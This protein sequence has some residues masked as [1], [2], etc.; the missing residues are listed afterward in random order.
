MNNVSVPD[1][2]GKKSTVLRSAV[3]FGANAAGKSNLFRALTAA[4]LMIRNSSIMQPNQPL[5]GIV[6]FEPDPAYHTKPTSFE[7]V[8]ITN[9]RK[10]V[11]GFS[12]TRERVVKE[13][14]YVYY[15]SKASTIFTRDVERDPEI[16]F[17]N[18]AI[19]RELSPMIQMNTP[20]K[21]FLSTATIWNSVTTKVPYLWFATNI[22]V[23]TNKYD[24]LLQFF[25]DM[26]DKDNVAG[27]REFIIKTMR[28][29]D[30]SIDGYSVSRHELSS[31]QMAKLPEINLLGMLSNLSI[32]SGVG[33]QITAKHHA[34]GVDGNQHNYEFTM[35]D[36][37]EGTRNIFMLSPLLMKTF[38]LGNV[39]C[40]DEFD[41]SFHPILVAYL[42]S[43]FH[44]PEINVG[45]AQLII[46]THT[47]DILSRLLFR[48]DQIYFVQKDSRTAASELYSLDEFSPRQ[49][50]D[51]RKS[52]LAGRYGSLP[53]IDE[54]F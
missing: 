51:F 48:R 54:V 17:T 44:N 9:G 11:Y 12:A 34:E 50:E 33:Y 53:L 31:E 14:L 43:L 49:M 38:Q 39:L 4:I 36:E 41:S 7:F 28:E 16:D 46:S 2:A 29:A 21:L 23:Y 6:P 3:M 18:P 30:V 32:T 37:S 52:Y 5:L 27:L 40:I 42:I 25:G 35:E 22:D 19:R 24:D 15:S 26:L 10:Y 1:V 47:T 20:N 8:F 45:N 13:Y